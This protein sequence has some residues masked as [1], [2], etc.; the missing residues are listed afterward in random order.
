MFS[1]Q[2]L[3]FLKKLK[4]PLSFLNRPLWLVIIPDFRVP[5]LFPYT[6]S[7]RLPKKDL[8]PQKSCSDE[9][10][11]LYNTSASSAD[12]LSEVTIAI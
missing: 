12:I 4:F 1:F 5:F 8:S 10:L 9:S 3:L 6:L 2:I 7:D 11:F